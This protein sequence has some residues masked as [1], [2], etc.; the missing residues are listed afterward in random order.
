MVVTYIFPVSLLVIV[1]LWTDCMPAATAT[2]E[3]EES[4][5]LSVN[6]MSIVP[7]FNAVVL[8]SER[9]PIMPPKPLRKVFVLSNVYCPV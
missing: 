7:L 1:P 8:A 4:D 3:L 5:E 9:I 6:T 2:E